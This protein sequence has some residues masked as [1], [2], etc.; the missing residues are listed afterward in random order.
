V[1]AAIAPVVQERVALLSEVPP[2]VDFLFLAEPP[3]DVDAWTTAVAKDDGAADILT[4]AVDTYEG[5]RE[6][7]RAAE[8]HEATQALADA[9]GRKLGKAQAPIRVAV[10]GRRVGP[11][12]FEALEVLGPDATLARLRTALARIGPA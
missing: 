3:V 9:V 8:L 12:L 2:M 1:F 6:R 4:R 5:C 10:T 7:W 11:P